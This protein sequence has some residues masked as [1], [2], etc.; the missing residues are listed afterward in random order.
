M[1][2]IQQTIKEFLEKY[3]LNNPENTYL[4]A[5]SGGYDS[6]CLLHSLKQITTQNRI[7]AIH[8]NH[9]WRGEES[10]QEEE[11]CRNFCSEIGV[12]FYSEKLSSDIPHT[13][14]AAREARY[15]F[16]ESYSKKFNSKIIFTAH[17]KNDNAETLI[18]RICKGTGIRGLC[19][20]AENR[21]IYYRP[22]LQISREKIEK[23]CSDFN[24]KP[25]NDS[26]NS[27]TSYK[28]NFIRAEIL[29][30]LNKKINPNTIEMVNSLSNA[31]REDTA[32]VEEYLNQL[33]TKIKQDN[34]IK[35]QEF[36]KLSFPT[37]KRIIY[38]LFIENNL[39]YDNEKITN[40]LENILN[41]ATS[42]SGKTSSLT[43]N[44]WIFTNNQFIEI[45]N[46]KNEKPPTLQIKKEGKY[47]TQDYIFTLEK[48]DQKT[49]HFPKENE[50][51]AIV[52]LENF[53][54]DFELRT[55]QNGDIIQ[56]FG[57]AGTQK[58][59]KYFNEKKVPQHEK[60]NILLLTQNKEV[61]WATGLGISDKIKVRTKP[62][63]KLT[64]EKKRG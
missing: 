31:A 20:I 51:T 28:R 26:S 62:T 54:F 39:D 61:L 48:Y 22:L 19:G 25:N 2:K 32:I 23:Y 7:V 50:N 55:R 9:N 49:T 46:K 45:I 16:F 11:N 36:L 60:S 43:T 8:L 64:I 18:Y 40:I 14:T 1:N 59:K 6:M 37:Q 35:T 53:D 33:Y 21:G 10:N 42:K 24:L 12:E 34:K 38:N 27:D 47:E 52:N 4:C 15:E 5:F 44:L 58:L 56:P 30:K 29:P 63:H 13:E 3:N 17:N 57:M 41:N